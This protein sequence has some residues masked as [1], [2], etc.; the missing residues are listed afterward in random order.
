M[1]AE[2]SPA[3]DSQSNGLAENAVRELKGVA[4]SLKFAV[5]NLHDTEIHAKHPILPWLISYA[6]AVIN[7]SQIGKDGLTPFRRW[8][9]RDFR[10]DLPPFGE[11]VLYLPPGKRAS[12][13]E[14]RWREGI[15]V[16]IADRS[17]EVLVA[18]PEGVKKARS[19]RRRADPERRN[20]ALVDGMIGLPWCPV[21]IS[22]DE[23]NIVP[24]VI[25]AEPV[26]AVGELPPPI[27]PVAL[28]LA[29]DESTSA[30]E[31]NC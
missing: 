20:K 9:G 12:R 22:P 15:F 24:A 11:V 6:A 13:L 3:G 14:D 4:R 28:L 17:A 8:R 7:R 21:P 31:L 23:A 2:E 26:V 16:G 30:K 1:I 18:T 5:A 25:H 29:L 19:V 27:V 10:R